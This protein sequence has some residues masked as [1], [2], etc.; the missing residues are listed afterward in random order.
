M[1][2]TRGSRILHLYLNN[3]KKRLLTNQLFQFNL[4]YKL[5]VNKP[6]VTCTSLLHVYSKQLP[7]FES[8]FHIK[9]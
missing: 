4:A 8:L 5:T 6:N 3:P 7:T 1:L 9:I 2:H